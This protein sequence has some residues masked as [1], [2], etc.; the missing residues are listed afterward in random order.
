MGVF[1]S[2][3]RR[4][5][6]DALP[7]QAGPAPTS[8]NTKHQLEP[9]HDTALDERRERSQLFVTEWSFVDSEGGPENSRLVGQPL[10]G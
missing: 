8:G 4:S 9:N 2:Y 10:A 7:P 3:L 5:D 1:M 6:D